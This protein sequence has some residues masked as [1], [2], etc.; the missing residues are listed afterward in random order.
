[1]RGE[2]EEREEEGDRERRGGERE[3]EREGEVEQFEPDLYLPV[4]R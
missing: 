2:R 3:K 1:M 4:V